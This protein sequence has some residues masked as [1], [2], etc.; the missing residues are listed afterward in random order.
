MRAGEGTEPVDREHRGGGG[1]GACRGCGKTRGRGVAPR[2][3]RKREESCGHV[4]AGKHGKVERVFA[5]C[6]KITK[7]SE[8]GP[9]HPTE[10]R[11]AGPSV[12]QEKDDKEHLQRENLRTGK[13][14]GSCSVPLCPLVTD[15]LAIAL[16]PFSSHVRNTS[17]LLCAETPV[18]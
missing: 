17:R 3:P 16:V 5:F 7:L 15:G 6:C 18:M 1:G 4:C 13:H 2:S 10:A 8:L 14:G 11:T 9:L 12:S